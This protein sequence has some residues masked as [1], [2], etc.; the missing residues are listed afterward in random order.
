MTLVSVLV[1]VLSSGL[2]LGVKD[3]MS[4]FTRRRG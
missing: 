2:G 1:V 3:S 4:L